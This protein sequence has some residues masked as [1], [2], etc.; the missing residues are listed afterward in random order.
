MN[1]KSKIVRGLAKVL[2]NTLVHL[3]PKK[4]RQLAEDRITLVHK[5]KKYLSLQEKLM[6]YALIQ[7][8][9]KIQDYD[10][11]AE[12]NREFWTNKGA[13]EFFTEVENTFET[14]FLPNCTF[15]FN[16][17]KKELL[18]VD[19]EFNTLVEIGT[20]NG[21]VLNYL[22]SEFPE[23]KRLVGIDLSLKQVE[24]N[25]NKFKNSN[26]RI[27]FVASDAFDWIKE[28]GQSGTI[29]VTSRGV[30]EYFLEERLQDFLSH[31]SQLGEIMFVAIEPN[32]ANHNFE[33][34]P[35]TQLYGLEPSFSHNYPKLFKNA[36]F[37]LWHF[38]Q[39]IWNNPTMN[40]TIIGAKNF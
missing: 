29:F 19:I 16:L 17:L 23:I 12:L 30:L 36:G 11:I 4:A 15:V 25:R 13:T 3:R 2:G 31:I 22:S 20:G 28:H 9:E 21:K 37:S 26:T 33:T 38:S 5:N 32:A 34:H 27:E 1:A 8:L 40:R 10:K 35:N 24:I 39:K 7:K 14:D 6:R 18:S